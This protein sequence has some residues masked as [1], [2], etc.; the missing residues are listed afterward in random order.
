MPLRDRP[1]LRCELDDPC[2]GALAH[3]VI[4]VL[5]KRVVQG[6]E[7]GMC[8]LKREDAAQYGFVLRDAIASQFEQVGSSTR[9]CPILQGGVAP[10]LAWRDDSVRPC[11]R[12]VAYLIVNSKAIKDQLGTHAADA[13]RAL[14]RLW[15][16]VEANP[17]A[18][19]DWLH[20]VESQHAFNATDMTY[21]VGFTP[22][23]NST[24]GRAVVGLNTAA[25]LGGV[26]DF[27][28][29]L[30]HGLLLGHDAIHVIEHGHIAANASVLRHWL[31]I[32]GSPS[33]VEVRA[34]LAG[35]IEYVVDGVILHTSS[36][37]ATF[38][39]RA[40]AGLFNSEVELRDVHWLDRRDMNT[41]DADSDAGEA[42]LGGMVW[43]TVSETGASGLLR[44][45]EQQHFNAVW[46]AQAEAANEAARR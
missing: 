24:I 32:D 18:T 39:L 2:I 22:H 21:G 10:S 13:A 6:H 17:R 45:D 19:G 41:P 33:R 4:A 34:N 14:K 5:L 1:L 25:G 30:Q 3:A 42:A 27:V 16:C 36:D 26:H 43:D 38:P 12:K 29:G 8:S 35:Y 11:T 28:D 46:S 23:F 9:R 44:P 7:R 37:R 40:V 31:L 15:P 20:G